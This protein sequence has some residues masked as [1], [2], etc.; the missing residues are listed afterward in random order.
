MKKLFLTTFLFT[1][2]GQSFA[3]NILG[4]KEGLTITTVEITN[5]TFS[6][7][8]DKKNVEAIQDELEV[9]EMTGEVR[10]EL[11]SLAMEFMEKSEEEMTL[12]EAINEVKKHFSEESK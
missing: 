9:Y 11:E 10:P 8:L 4:P 12:V 5:A 3:N 2:F 6:G 1:M 7:L